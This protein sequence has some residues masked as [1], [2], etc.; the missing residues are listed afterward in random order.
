[1]QI[2]AHSTALSR[3]TPLLSLPAVILD[4]ETTGLDIENDRIVQIAC[5]PMNGGQIADNLSIDNLVNPGVNIPPESTRIHH[6]DNDD[7]KDA[8]SFED[9]CATL[10]RQISGRVVVGHNIAFDLAVLRFEAARAGIEWQEPVSLDLAK[11]A[12]ALAPSLPDV[13]F[14][15]IARWLEVDVIDRHT[16]SGDVKTTAAAF[17]KLISR[18][19]VANVRTL[20]EA[21]TL[22][23]TSSDMTLDQERAGWHKQPEVFRSGTSHTLLPGVDSHI[24]L[25]RLGDVM[26]TPVHFVDQQE[27]LRGA[28]KMMVANG[29]GSVLVGDPAEP[30][31]GILTERDLMCAVSEP[32]ADIDHQ[33]VA[34]FMSAPVECL[35]ENEFLYRALARMARCGVR[36]LVVTDA[37]GIAVGV[38]SERDLVRYRADAANILGDRLAQAVNVAQLASAHGSLCEVARTLCDEG[39]SGVQIAAVIS[40]EMQALTARAA[41]MAENA[42]AKDGHGRAPA[43]WCLLV[44]G[45]AGRAESLLSADQDNAVIHA[46]SEQDDAWFARF[47]ECIANIL[48]ESGLPRCTGGVMASNS[49][50]RGTQSQWQQRVDTW[51]TRTKPADLLSVDIFYDLYPAAGD[52]RLGEELKR[53]ALSRVN[54]RGPFLGILANSVVASGS[55]F[56]IFGRLRTVDGRVDL[57]MQG[58]LPLVSCARVLA[59]KCESVSANTPDRLRDA[60]KAGL[61]AGEDCERLIQTQKVLLSLILAQQIR[62]IES[63]IPISSSVHVSTLNRRE[64]SDLKQ[65]LSWLSDIVTSLRAVIAN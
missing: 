27:T 15:T 33:S 13:G 57:K 58:L 17:S 41:E 9:Q 65:Q 59:L 45:S 20:G 43:P 31:L 25:R 46:G 50:W 14:E 8:G 38:V 29:I 26:S 5:M 61:I 52:A 42:I 19:R 63:G 39:L 22:Q 47:G 4:L 34:A 23:T 35:G 30:P 21:L 16:A 62:D 60:Q 7:V 28:A 54:H 36:H 12:R 49:A 3:A 24:Y 51:L 6:I 2:T 32:D 53:Y 40:H 55:P 1:M 11:L 18:L 37:N 10:T 64:V 44:L 48:H 56:G